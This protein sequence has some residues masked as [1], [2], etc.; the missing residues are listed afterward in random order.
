M[1][2]EINDVLH[3]CALHFLWI[4]WLLKQSTTNYSAVH[5]IRQ[6]LAYFFVNRTQNQGKWTSFFV[7]SSTISA[8]H[9]AVPFPDGKALLSLP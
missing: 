7:R 9:A 4:L 8:Y 5:V 6:L 1:T 3:G 2:M